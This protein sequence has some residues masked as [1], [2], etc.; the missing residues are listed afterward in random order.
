[1]AVICVPI[2][3]RGHEGAMKKIARANH[4][5]DMIELRLD[6]MK[7]FCLEE[8]LRLPRKIRTAYLYYASSGTRRSVRL[9][10][11][12]R[13]ATLSA[14]KALRVLLERDTPPKVHYGPKCFKCSLNAVCL[15]QETETIR[16][17]KVLKGV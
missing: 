17:Q 15:L 2:I 1:M 6:S 7:S 9:G 3:D 13:S 10:R 12:L 8:M 16:K 4:L 11:G 14:I 5:A